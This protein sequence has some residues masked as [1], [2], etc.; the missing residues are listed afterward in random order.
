M[1]IKIRF[2]SL[3]LKGSI[4]L[5]FIFLE[6]FDFKNKVKNFKLKNEVVGCIRKTQI[7][8]VCMQ[9]LKYEIQL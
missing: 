5:S 3:L 8:L 2:F 9:K 6:Q 1:S 7:L 4:V